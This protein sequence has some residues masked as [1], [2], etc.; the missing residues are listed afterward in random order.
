M[1]AT[2]NPSAVEHYGSP[3][4]TVSPHPAAATILAA[5]HLCHGVPLAA[6]TAAAGRLTPAIMALILV[7]LAILGGVARGLA[8][9]TAVLLRLAAAMTSVLFILVIIIVV[10]VVVLMHH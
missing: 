2:W 4:N 9:L 7:I 8:D 5:C 10:A 3:L 1:P 6:T